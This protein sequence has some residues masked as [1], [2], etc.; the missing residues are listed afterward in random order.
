MVAY[1]KWV[2][3]GVPKG[4]R[5]TG[6]GTQ[7]LELLKRAADAKKGKQVFDAQCSRCHG[8]N[9]EG[10]KRFDSSGYAY[11]P[12]WGPDSYNTGAGLYRL[13][14]LSAYIHDNM[15]YGTT[16]HESPQLTVEQS[17]DVAAFISSQPR[18]QK[19]FS[20]DWPK[21]SDKAF[22]YPFG[23]YTDHFNESEHK[24]GPFEPIKKE[25]AAMAAAKK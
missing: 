15:P 13:S 25:K 18:P 10:Q 4:V 9:G 1:L 17:W 14:K 11:P 6:A 21:L 23:P 12:L 8:A 24:Y 3:A 22:D 2:G 16:S 7:D 20:E 5:P 19:R